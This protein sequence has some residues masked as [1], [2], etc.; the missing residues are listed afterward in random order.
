MSAAQ[1]ET[2]EACLG[3]FCVATNA[4]DRNM[5]TCMQTIMGITSPDKNTWWYVDLGNVHSVYN[6]RVQFRDY[7]QEYGKQTFILS[8]KWL[9]VHR[10]QGNRCS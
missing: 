5:S 2:Y 3:P 8:I 7:G 4:V 6:I 10:Q 9:I 1:F